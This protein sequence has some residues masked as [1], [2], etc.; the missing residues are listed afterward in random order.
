MQTLTAWANQAPVEQF[1]FVIVLLALA[2]LAA[3]VYAYRFFYRKRLIED[4]PTSKIRS[5]AQGYVELEGNSDLMDGPPIIAPLSKK[6]CVWYRFKVE[7]RQRSGNNNHWVVVNEGISDDLF[8][9]KDETGQ[10]VI[11]PEGA[12]VTPT[13]KQT[14]SGGKQFLSS[15]SSSK[16]LRYTEQRI[17][18]NDHLYAIGL[19]RNEG[20]AGSSMDINEDVRELLR[21]WKRDSERMLAQFDA[22]GDGEIDM[23]EWE[24]A[25]DAAYKIVKER[26]ADEKIT[27]PTHM[28]EQTRDRRRPFILSA[29][30]QP[31]LL[32]HLNRYF[33]SLAGLTALCLA[34]SL[35]LVSIRF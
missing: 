11:D 33:Y 34:S 16:K 28:L 24:S 2:T 6:P 18:T 32:V 29:K 10:C 25:R 30:P 17:N 19:F 22:N 7:E 35:W 21:E 13:L 15:T 23:Q 8:L 9:L 31:D 1:W 26:H 4:M 14:W 3:F 20:G 5:A 27:M 12:Q